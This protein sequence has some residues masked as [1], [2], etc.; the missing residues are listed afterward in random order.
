M[1][2]VVQFSGGKDSTAL[3][4]WAREQ[5]G[6]DGFTA[7]FCD[8]KWE[9]PLTYEYVETINREV[10]GGKLVTLTSEKYHGLADLSAKRK[11]VPSVRMRFC[12]QELKL[13]PCVEWMR[14]QEYDEATVYQ[15]IRADESRVRSTYPARVYEPLYDGW[16]ERPLFEWTAEQCFDLMK[17]HA[18]EPNP[19]YKMGARRVGCFPCIMVSKGELRRLSKT[20]PEIWDQIAKVENSVKEGRGFF[21]TDYIPARF[22][23]GR[24]CEI[25]AA[26]APKE[27]TF[28]TWQDVKRY[29]TEADKQQA[30]LFDACPVGGCMSVYNLC[31]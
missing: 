18:I 16:I 6:A 14:A 9:H 28:P 29:I 25:Q 26:G 19:L 24:Y 13:F 5:F 2:R 31:E 10:L 23:T 30:R 8:T 15:G 12:T 27:G 4:L 21:R 20:M 17:K 7:V 3:V 22:H 1:L 11:I